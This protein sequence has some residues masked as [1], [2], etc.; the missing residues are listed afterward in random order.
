MCGKLHFSFRILSSPFLLGID[1]KMLPMPPKR[2]IMASKPM[3]LN[4]CAWICSLSSDQNYLRV[5]PMNLRITLKPVMN[6]LWSHSLQSILRKRT[7]VNTEDTKYS[8]PFSLPVQQILALAQV[9]K[10]IFGETRL[11]AP[12]PQSL[13]LQRSPFP[14]PTMLP[15][16]RSS[17]VLVVCWKNYHCK[18]LPSTPNPGGCLVVG[19]YCERATL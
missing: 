1:I 9:E 14:P 3:N 10:A 16:S 19:C 11:V 6:H 8:W 5:K 15:L 4:S 13:S 17:E 7:W 2:H 12:N 18:W